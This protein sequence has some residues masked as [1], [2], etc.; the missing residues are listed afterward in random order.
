MGKRIPVPSDF[1][2]LAPDSSTAELAKAYG[3]SADTVRRWR[4]EC[5]VPPPKR[6]QAMAS[7]KYRGM[8]TPEQIRYCLHCPVK[9]CYGY[10]CPILPKVRNQKVRRI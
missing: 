8:D 1:R 2:E 4:R 6:N 3:C 9:K 10:K 5:G 7:G